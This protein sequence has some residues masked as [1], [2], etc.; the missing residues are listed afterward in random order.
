MAAEAF[1]SAG[2]YTVGIPPISIINTNG[3]ITAPYAN[4]NGNLDVSGNIT[5]T[6]DLRADNIYGNIVGNTIGNVVISAPE[7]SITFVKSGT[8]SGNNNFTYNEVNN[9]VTINGDLIANTLTMGAG[10][11]EFSSTKML[12]ASTNS[13]GADQVLQSVN[14]TN[15]SAVEYMIIADDVT[16]NSRQ[17]TK[18]L[19]SILGT[20]IAYSEF[21]TIDINGGVGDFKVQ[22]NT[23]NIELTV[24]PLLSNPASYKIMVTT[25]K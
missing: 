4:I 7:T 13:A 5:A 10:S 22:Y 14:G 19:A 23:G 2:G 1:N 18:L 16:A 9:V 17:T 12:F 6:G 3:N 24:S 25:Y 8:V 21:G 11:Y 20:Q 15:H